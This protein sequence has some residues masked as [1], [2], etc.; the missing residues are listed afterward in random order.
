MAGALAGGAELLFRAATGVADLFSGMAAALVRGGVSAVA[1]MQYEIPD[2]AAVA[3]ARGDLAQT[4]V[5]AVTRRTGEKFSRQPTVYAGGQFQMPPDPRIRAP[6]TSCWS[7]EASLPPVS[8][9][10]VGCGT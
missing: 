8:G 5:S 9:W 7:G 3:F 2:P 6:L 1:A 10:D 4:S